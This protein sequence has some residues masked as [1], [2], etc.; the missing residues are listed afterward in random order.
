MNLLHV[1]SCGKTKYICTCNLSLQQWT[2]VKVSGAKPPV[3]NSHA[4]CC[5]AGLPTGQHHPLLMVVGGWY[6]DASTLNDVWLLDVDRGV[7]SEVGM[8]YLTP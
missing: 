4:I 5:I 2:K 8:S 3:R 6:T 1:A 7:W